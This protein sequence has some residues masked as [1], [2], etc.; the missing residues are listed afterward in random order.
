MAQVLAWPVRLLL[1]FH[2]FRGADITHT[3]ICLRASSGLRMNLRVRRV[4][5]LSDILSVGCRNNRRKLRGKEVDNCAPD[6]S[7]K[8]AQARTCVWMF[9]QPSLPPAKSH[10]IHHA[11]LFAWF[12]SMLILSIKVSQGRPWCSLKKKEE[13]VTRSAWWSTA[14][15]VVRRALY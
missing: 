1:V 5:W 12:A 11:A 9:P 14:Y 4:T 6:D 2:L 7:A 8:F 15:L 10:E 13:I 3:T